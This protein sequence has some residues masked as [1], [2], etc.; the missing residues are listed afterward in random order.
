MTMEQIQEYLDLDFLGNS[1]QQYLIALVVFYVTF[2][3]LL[4]FRSRLLA[5]FDRLSK[6]TS[7]LYDDLVIHLIQSLGSQFY[8]IV[9][10]LVGLHFLK[11]AEWFDPYFYSMKLAVAVFYVVRLIQGGVSFF[12]E[13]FIHKAEKESKN[14]DPSILQFL[15]LTLKV[16]ALLLGLLI[17]LQNLGFNVTALVG[18]LG[19]GGIA[20]AFALQNVL[21]D[22][23]A[24]LS[25]FF[26]K[27]FKTGDFIVLGADMGTVQKIGI[28]STR[29]K[30]LQ[31]E[32]LVVSNQELT[33]ARVQNFK[34]LDKRRIVF[35]LNL[36]YNTTSAK[37]EKALKIIEDVVNAEGVQTELDRTH[38]ARFAAS[39]L[40]IETVYYV[41]T[42]DFQVYMDEQQRINFGIKKAFEK[43]GIEFAFPTQTVHVEK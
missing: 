34:Q 40:D 36:V 41:Q 26:D 12:I 18:G 20:I 31:G 19:I 43:A 15:G 32:T 24:S 22:I 6:K 8:L 4:L 13:E 14:F 16:V 29:I 1:V 25:I 42:G 17:I 35:T 37:L 23:F 9:S 3:V 33:T 27:P 2:M 7:T 5:Y 39:S 38:F 21:S 30:T 11:V 10:F 28:R